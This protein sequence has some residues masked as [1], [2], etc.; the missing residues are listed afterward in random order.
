MK[1]SLV[2]VGEAEGSRSACCRSSSLQQQPAAASDVLLCRSRS[3]CEIPHAPSGNSVH[4][5]ETRV[6]DGAMTRSGSGTG[7]SFPPFS[8][9]RTDDAVP[10]FGPSRLSSSYSS[11]A[12]DDYHCH[13][14]LRRSY[15]SR[16]PLNSFLSMSDSGDGV[17]ATSQISLQR[18]CLPPNTQHKQISYS[19]GIRSEAVHGR[20]APCVPVREEGLTQP[21]P[22]PKIAF[23]KEQ[24]DLITVPRAKDLVHTAG[25]EEQTSLSSPDAE[26]LVRTMEPRK[27][28]HP[29]FRKCP[30]VSL[31]IN[32]SND[33]EKVQVIQVSGISST[34]RMRFMEILNATQSVET[35]VGSNFR[36]Q[37]DEIHRQEKETS[38]VPLV[39]LVCAKTLLAIA[40]KLA[41]FD[42]LP[43]Q[44]KENLLK[45]S[46]T[47]ILFLRSAKFFNRSS[48]C[49]IFGSTDSTV[50]IWR[51]CLL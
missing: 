51:S 44:D 40:E 16:I 12:R 34:E 10:V 6:S 14:Q 38:F 1:K 41:V 47:E 46:L 3:V 37:S 9:R 50:S 19:Q 22:H 33:P 17:A 13:Q 30:P 43:R 24:A 45:G 8:D 18:N 23:K 11:L 25:D 39:I 36:R 26:Q 5:S 35:G 7:A 49:W 20:E 32:I 48:Q 15:F 28:V 42:L 21:R 31:T 29:K 27:L 2:A 4:V